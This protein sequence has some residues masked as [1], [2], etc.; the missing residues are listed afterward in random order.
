MRTMSK[1]GLT[2]ILFVLLFA[3]WAGSAYA[4]PFTYSNWNARYPTSL[5]DDKILAVDGTVCRL[6][7]EATFGTDGWNGYGWALRNVGSDFALVEG[8]NSDQDPG[9]YSN[10]SEISTGAQPGWTVGDNTIYYKNGSTA[11]VSAPAVSPLDTLQGT[12]RINFGATYVKTTAVTLTLTLS[13][14][15]S[16]SLSKMRFSNDGFF[17]DTAG[18]E[19]WRAYSTTMGWT[20]SP[21]N[22]TRT[23][24]AQFKDGAGN[25]S[26]VAIDTIVLDTAK[27]MAA[28]SSPDYASG[29]SKTDDFKVTWTGS[30][31]GSGIANYT[32]QYK[33]GSGG[34]WTN[35]KTNTTAKSA[36]FNGS[37]SKTYYFKSRAKDKAGNIG[38][39]SAVDKTVVPFDQGVFSASGVWASFT[40]SN[41]YKGTSKRSSSQGAR[42]TKSFSGAKGVALIVT[43]RPSGG[44]AKVF[45]G[46]EL[47][48]TIN[49][50][51]SAIKYRQ[52][53]LIKSSTT[54]FFGTLKVVVNG[55]HQ[56][57]SSG[58]R[59]EVDGV[60]IRK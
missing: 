35:R 17:D 19:Q 26:D 23:V 21:G 5:A 14:T 31:S 52:A 32:V 53:I 18:A 2:F 60:G 13:A 40:D 25:I 7:H 34:T 59:V 33:V 46:T 20:L 27:P 50:Y 6:C 8:A 56:A 12:V 47:I 51:S 55:A 38:N 9:G 11:T 37:V 1:T 54:S 45:I 42:L 16:V 10:L 41:L 44:Y 3:A 29:V 48:K 24:R 39:W 28:F 36:I 58:N 30:D 43:K 49:L 57:G 4:R 22:G 15:D